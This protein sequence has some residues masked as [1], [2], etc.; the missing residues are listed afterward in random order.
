MSVLSLDNL[1]VRRCKSIFLG[2][3]FGVFFGE[4]NF[5]VFFILV[6]LNSQHILS[7]LNN[8][9]GFLDFLFHVVDLVTGLKKRLARNDAELVGRETMGTDVGLH[10]LI[11]MD[12]GLIYVGLKG[13][14]T[15]NLALRY[16]SIALLFDFIESSGLL[17][18]LLSVN[19]ELIE[20]KL[21]FCSLD[22]LLGF[23]GLSPLLLQ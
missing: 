3:E 11:V 15:E 14:F 23:L 6:L 17:Q 13:F 2:E 1:E 19:L 16:N 7:V 9:S 5:V 21:I 12:N 8:S 10:E 4:S 20:F 18:G 22:L